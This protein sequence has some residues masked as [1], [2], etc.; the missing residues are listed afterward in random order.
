MSVQLKRS[1]S[2]DALNMTPL[3]DVVFILLIF[4]LV[5]AKFANED[6]ELPVQLP[7]AKSAMPM[8]TEP[9]VMTVGIASDGTLAVDGTEMTLDGVESAIQQAV[10]NNPNNQTV[11]I[12]GD[13]RVPF[14]SVVAVMDA[15]NR[16]K[17]PSYKVTTAPSE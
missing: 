8:T 10:I 17:V 1:R 4:F 12:R 2:L 13:K 16:L 7:T 3:I 5:A 9:Q 6:R 11:I 15:C 14:Q